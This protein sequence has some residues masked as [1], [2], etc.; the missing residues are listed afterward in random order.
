M[1]G[2]D[3]GSQEQQIKQEVFQ[4]VSLDVVV[5]DINWLS[6]VNASALKMERW[7]LVNRD[8]KSSWQLKSNHLAEG[9]KAKNGNTKEGV[10]G[11]KLKWDDPEEVDPKR[12]G[13]E[14]S[15]V[16]DLHPSAL[17]EA[18]DFAKSGSIMWHNKEGWQA[19][20]F[21]AIKVQSLADLVQF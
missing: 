17:L 10:K 11:L 8:G 12:R 15:I 7:A 4:Q 18:G 6:G 2:P 13:K 9:L 14:V 5:R 16:P 3:G 21:T 19:R 1:T 20:R